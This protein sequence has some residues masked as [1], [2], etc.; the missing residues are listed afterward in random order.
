MA[1]FSSFTTVTEGF[2]RCRP[3]FEKG[4]RRLYGFRAG[5]RRL[6]MGWDAALSEPAG[7]PIR[8]DANRVFETDLM[9]NRRELPVRNGMVR[10]DLDASPR[11]WTF[12]GVSVLKVDTEI[13]SAV[14]ERRLPIAGDFRLDRIGCV[15]EV[16]PADP[17]TSHRCWKGIGDCSAEVH[18][19]REGSALEIA[20]SVSDDRDAGEDAV[21]LVF[22][23]WKLEVVRRVPRVSREGTTTVYRGRIECPA[24]PYECLEIRVIDDDG[25]GED[26]RLVHR[27]RLR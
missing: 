27:F 18:V 12:E 13:L 16:Y 2:G 25:E 8:T 9:G 23:G 10:I 14:A 26:L 5:D 24:R 17:L 19:R 6:V 22:I 4:L 20:V 15:K 7:I 21:E 1:A 11:A 3:L